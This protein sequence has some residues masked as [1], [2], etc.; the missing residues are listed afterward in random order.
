MGW[1]CGCA[2]VDLQLSAFPSASLYDVYF[3]GVTSWLPGA[4]LSL[5]FTTGYDTKYYVGI[6]IVFSLSICP[7]LFTSLLKSH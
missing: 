3:L 4:I 1:M 7:D 6:S 2:C 5:L